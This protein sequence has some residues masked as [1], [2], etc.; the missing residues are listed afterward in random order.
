MNIGDHKFFSI[1]VSGFLGYNPSSGIAVSKGSSS[2]KS[3]WKYTVFHSGCTSLH[4]HQQYTRVP[5]SPQSRQHLLLLDLFMM[6]ILTSVKWYLIVVLFCISLLTTD[7]EHPFIYLWTLCMS[8]LE[9][10]LFRFFA[11]FFKRVFLFLEFSDFFIDFGDQTLLQD[12]I[13]KYVF[14]YCWFSFN[15]NAVFFS[16]E[17]AFYFDEVPFVYSFPYVLCSRGHIVENIASWNI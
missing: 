5:F 14:P 7:T 2:F 13:G 1:G 4:S 10:C 3:L 12:I 17:E 9:K 11:H 8:S 15:F 16:C 6:A